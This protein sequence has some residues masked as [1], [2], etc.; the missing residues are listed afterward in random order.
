MRY[1]LTILLLCSA[2][3]ASAQ[4]LQKTVG[5]GDTDVMVRIRI[6]DESDGTPETGVEHNTSG[7]DLKYQRE[8][9][10]NVDITEAALSALTDAHSD[11]GIEHIGNGYYRLDV[12]DAAFATGAD[13]VLIHG[14]V[15]GMTVIGCTV[16]ITQA[17]TV[18][19]SGHVTPADGS[20]TEAKF[21]DV[22]EPTGVPPDS[23]INPM[24]MIS[25]LY[26]F[27]FKNRTVEDRPNNEHRH[28]DSSGNVEFERTT[29]VSSGVASKGKV[30]AAD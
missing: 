21:A 6:V 4:A 23:S 13:T 2:S 26:H 18:N 16:Q 28:Y 27:G 10:A 14:T 29:S 19:S 12:P 20:I 24:E 1:L 17:L 15:T 8:G 11:G 7:I 9:A 25:W 22:T 30:E 3:L 5:I